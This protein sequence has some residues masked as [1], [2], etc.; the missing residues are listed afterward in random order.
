MSAVT[1]ALGRASAFMSAAVLAACAQQAADPSLVA[2]PPTQIAV[3]ADRVGHGN[4]DGQLRYVASMAD[5]VSACRQDEEDIEIDI[6][7]VMSAERGPAFAEQPV[8]LTYFLATVNPNRDIV[9]KQLLDVQFA[10]LP[11]QPVS[12]LRETLTLRL[13]ASDEAS[14]ANYSLYLGFQLDQ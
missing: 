8:T 6:S 2:C 5:L 13:P 11:E 1:H 9:D 12:A 3:P 4:D 14:G 10:F 7:F